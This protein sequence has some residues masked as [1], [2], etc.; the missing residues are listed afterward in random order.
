MGL[1]EDLQ[2]QGTFLFRW[3]SYLPLLLLPLFG[4]ALLESGKLEKAGFQ[5]ADDCFEMFCFL[6]SDLGLVIRCATVGSKP[7]RTSGRGTRLDAKA[8]N[9]TGMYS[10]VRHP[11]YLGNFLVGFGM[12]MFLQ[13]GWFVLAYAMVFGL[14]YERIMYAEEEYLRSRFRAQFEEWSERTPAFFPRLSIWRAPSLPFS[15]K[16]V[17]RREYSTFFLICATFF[18]IDSLD[19]VLLERASPDLAWVAVLAVGAA[20]YSVLLF[21]KRTTKLLAV[22]GR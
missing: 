22:P 16:A 1:R 17:L 14:Y 20:V 21:L 13:S 9:T 19:D 10:V 8:L 15:F 3:R 18:T 4:A 2:R 11:L 5:L 7:A 12:A 6:V